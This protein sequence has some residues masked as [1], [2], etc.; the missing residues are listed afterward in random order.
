MKKEEKLNLEVEIIGVP[1]IDSLS[2][3]DKKSF[4]LELLM[5]AKDYYKDKNTE[6]IDKNN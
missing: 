5:F 3:D 2:T 6:P 4:A 1:L